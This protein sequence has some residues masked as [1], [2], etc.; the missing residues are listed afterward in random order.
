MAVYEDNGGIA[1][2]AGAS[3]AVPYPATVNENDI[4]ILQVV[5]NDDDTFSAVTGFTSI[6]SENA[7]KTMSIGFWWKRA[8][9][10]ESGTITVDSALPVGAGIF[11]VI[12]RYSGCIESG[13]PYEDP[14]GVAVSKTTTPTIPA[15]TNSGGSRLAVGLVSML[16]D[17][18]LSGETDYT[19]AFQQND[20]NGCNLS[21]YYQI[22]SGSPG[23]DA[24]SSSNELIGLLG[25]LLIPKPFVPRMIMF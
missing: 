23:S 13:T 4:L 24:L 5:D 18:A 2:D 21:G 11:G 15:M 20:A 3:V 7:T 8:T 9:G 6:Y 19:E 10:L 25:I 17:V 14:T 16:A 22:T 12:S 1:F